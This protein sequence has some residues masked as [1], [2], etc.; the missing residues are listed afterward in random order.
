M[1]S[2]PQII[3]HVRQESFFFVQRRPAEHS[4]LSLR[5]GQLS[6][7]AAAPL[8]AHVAKPERAGQ[9]SLG[10]ARERDMMTEEWLDQLF[11]V[12]LDIS[13]SL[14]ETVAELTDGLEFELVRP[15]INAL[16]DVEEI[17]GYDSGPGSLKGLAWED[18]NF[19]WEWWDEWVEEVGST[20]D[21]WDHALN[22]DDIVRDTISKATTATLA[23]GE[24]L[25]VFQIRRLGVEASLG[26]LARFRKVAVSAVLQQF[27]EVLDG[28]V[29]SALTEITVLIER[30]E[31]NGGEDKI[32]RAVDPELVAIVR[33]IGL[34]LGRV[35]KAAG[36][37]SVESSKS[38]LESAK[39][40]RPNCV[41]PW[42][43][44]FR[45]A[46]GQRT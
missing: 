11:G 17:S 45:L 37:A 32:L 21:W 1:V 33:R 22:R 40:P 41:R 39:P 2:P 14:V 16:Q 9:T 36:D 19:S 6:E 30:S 25:D 23:R 24:T 34:D 26:A 35:V 44:P 43:Q 7:L 13:H 3:A 4:N 42:K 20:D 12:S 38:E 5:H 28:A 27:R 18:W 15:L 8:G 29:Q 46:G 31:D 10:D